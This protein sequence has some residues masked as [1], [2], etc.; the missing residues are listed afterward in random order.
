MDGLNAASQR[1]GVLDQVEQLIE[2]R[3][4]AW[5]LNGMTEAQA[6]NQLL[7]LSDFAGRDPTGFIKYMAENSGVNLEDLVFGEEPADPQTT[8]LQRRLAAAEARITGFD[9]QQQQAAHTNTVNAVIGFASEKA[10][11]G[12]LLRPHFEELGNGI[13][14]FISTVKAQNPSWS[15]NQVLQTAYENACW[16][17]PAVRAKMQAGVSATAEAERIRTETERVTRAKAASVSVRS[18]AP[19]SPATAPTEGSG[20]LRDTI[21]ASIAATN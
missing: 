17:T 15:Q 8:E 12:S 21:R 10:A 14:P 11:D 3:R 4:Q 5:A 20:T 7:S 18:G 2:P 9:T 19:S 13:L 6:I 1:L 16:G